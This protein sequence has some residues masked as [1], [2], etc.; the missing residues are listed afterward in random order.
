MNR[1]DRLSAI[2]IQLQSKRLVKAQDIADKFSISLRTVYRDVR[3]LEEAGVP[4][5]GE[6]GS[7]AS[8]I[9]KHQRDGDAY[10][11]FDEHLLEEAGDVL[12]YVV[13]IASRLG[14]ELHQWPA[15]DP[16]DRG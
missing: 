16:C 7:L 14:I 2:L 13:T 12:W 11:N 8:V 9:K 4:I 5:I 3:A 10:A 1:I 6:A 15:H